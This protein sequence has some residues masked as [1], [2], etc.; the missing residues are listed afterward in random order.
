M[1]K[2][3]KLASARQKDYGDAER[4]L[5]RIGRCWGATL[6]TADIPA[7]TVALM[8]AQLKIMRIVDKRKVEDSF[9]DLGGYSDIARG[10]IDEH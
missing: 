8:M 5:R 1:S 3:I 7:E 10:I 2:R 4:N 9:D 6:G